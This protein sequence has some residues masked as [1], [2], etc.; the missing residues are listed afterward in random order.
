MSSIPDFVHQVQ[1]V[2]QKLQAEWQSVQAGWQ[3][4]VAERFNE[5]VMI[6]YMKNF[7]QYITGEGISGY[8][9]EQLLQQMER[10]LQDMASLTSC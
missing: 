2:E 1:E 9:L 3:D 6:P 7:R 10:H 4:S 8:G 5:G